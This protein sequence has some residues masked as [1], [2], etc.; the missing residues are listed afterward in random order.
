MKAKLLSGLFLLFVFLEASPQ[1]YA[2]HFSPKWRPVFQSAKAGDTIIFAFN[3]GGIYRGVSNQMLIKVKPRKDIEIYFDKG[4]VNNLGDS[5]FELIPASLGE[6]KLIINGYPSYG[7]ILSLPYPEKF[8]LK[9]FPYSQTEKQLPDLL[10]GITIRD[11]MRYPRIEAKFKDYIYTVKEFQC[12]VFDEYGRSD[13]SPVF[14]SDSIS[15][16]YLKSLDIKHH[17]VKLGLG[18]IK[19]IAP[20]ST[21]KVIY[22]DTGGLFAEVYR[23]ST[24]MLLGRYLVNNTSQDNYARSDIRILVDGYPGKEDIET[25]RTIIEELNSVLTTINIKLVKHFP[26]LVIRFDKTD[27]EFG[28]GAIKGT[29]YKTGVNQFYPLLKY[30]RVFINTSY[31]NQQERDLILWNEISRSLGKFNRFDKDQSV[32]SSII[33]ENSV[34]GLTYE[35]NLVL[36]AIFSPGGDN[37]INQIK[38]APVSSPNKH[39]MLLIL[40]STMFFFIIYE[41]NNYFNFTLIIKNQIFRKV[42]SSLIISQIAVVLYFLILSFL[43]KDLEIQYSF[44][45]LE[46]Y[47][48]SFAIISGLLFNIEDRISELFRLKW[49]RLGLNPLLSI[50]FLYLAY[51]IV[52][53][54]VRGE[55][56]KII[57]IDVNAFAIGFSIV[58][59]R[60]YL[61]YEQLKIASL[62]QEKEYELTRH[63]EMQNRAELN[64]L[65]ARINPHFLYNALNSIAALAHIDSG[66]TESMA[67]SLAKLFRYTLNRDEKM[68]STIGQEIEM[69]KL[70]LEIEKHR[71]EERL[72][73]QILVGENIVEKVVPRLL[74]QPLVENSIKH[75]ISKITGQGCII[76]KVFEQKN[77]LV[78]EIFDN[79]PEFP[80]GLLS[81]YGLQNTYDKLTMVYKKPYEIKFINSPEKHI[82]IRLK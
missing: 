11:L 8:L 55:V 2:K 65:H 39:I 3:G 16:D 27:T 66:R 49:I 36:R 76:V 71:F 43:Y 22:G 77:D 12:I 67:L 28:E 68:V 63:K 74:I 51:Q 54:F 5:L 32:T 10:K 60:F 75:G 26:S 9:G 82:S 78:I 57:T 31:T 24:D 53:L 81:G 25:V 64:A 15:I 58:A 59:V 37:L 70:Y 35:D 30:F 17:P 38:E 20:D 56:L 23:D 47:A 79:G 29:S 44:L 19:L 4:I 13:F 61:H 7:R 21:E 46:L 69:V 34:P 14:K 45:K 80:E 52:Y 50:V 40:L 42:I 41:I 33:G 18:N 48:G 73:F 62:M 1:D 72:D 6:Y